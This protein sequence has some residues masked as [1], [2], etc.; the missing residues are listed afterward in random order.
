MLDNGN[1]P[2][3]DAVRREW[4]VEIVKLLLAAK[5]LSLH[6][7]FLTLLILCCFGQLW[8]RKEKSRLDLM[9]DWADLGQLRCPRIV[10]T[11]HICSRL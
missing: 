2:L 6:P 8:E 4:P 5:A 3:H 7:G 10:Q 9:L 1:T 11:A